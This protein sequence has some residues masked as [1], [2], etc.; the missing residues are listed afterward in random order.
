M[1]PPSLGRPK[2]WIQAALH[3]RLSK[4][5]D[6]LELN[7]MCF[8]WNVAGKMPQQPEHFTQL[9]QL[10]QLH[11]ASIVALAFQEAVDLNASSLSIDSIT[12]ESQSGIDALL[13]V[14]APLPL[15]HHVSTRHS[16]CLPGRGL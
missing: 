2:S 11:D 9:A 8:T 6:L 13:H 10:I 7:I 15:L 14:R 3:R 4:W 5:A 12:P 16:L 1:R